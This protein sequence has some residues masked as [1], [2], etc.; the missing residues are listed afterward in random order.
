[1]LFKPPA[2]LGNKQDRDKLDKLT[3]KQLV[4]DKQIQ[5]DKQTDNMEAWEARMTEHQRQSR[6]S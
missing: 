5:T 4:R 2:T 6:P 1:M 3:D